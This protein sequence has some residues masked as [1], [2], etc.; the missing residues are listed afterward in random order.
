MAVRLREEALVTVGWIAQ[1]LR[2]GSVAHVN[3]LLY[4][5]RQGK[6]QK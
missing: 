3:T 6:H 5:W 1:C 2:M 4:H